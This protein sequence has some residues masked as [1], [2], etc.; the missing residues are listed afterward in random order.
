MYVARHKLICFCYFRNGVRINLASVDNTYETV[1]NNLEHYEPVSM[2]KATLP[3]HQSS[4]AELNHYESRGKNSCEKD[5]NASVVEEKDSNMSKIE[6]ITEHSTHKS[7]VLVSTD[8]SD[9]VDN[10]MYGSTTVK[11]STQ[12]DDDMVDNPMY[13]ST[14]W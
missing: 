2:L 11:T 5:Q 12:T 8:D 14:S 10:P 4:S 1:E 7:D 3:T 9:M 13:G 6:Q